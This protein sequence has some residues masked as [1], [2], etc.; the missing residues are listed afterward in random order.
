MR[1]S[2]E[3]ILLAQSLVNR[4]GGLGPGGR[5]DTGG[6]PKHGV[7]VL[8]PVGGNGAH[9][10]TQHVNEAQDHL[11][12]QRRVRADRPI[13]AEERGNRKKNKDNERSHRRT[14]VVPPQPQIKSSKHETMLFKFNFAPV[15]ISDDDHVEPGS[16]DAITVA[17]SAVVGSRGLDQAIHLVREGP[18]HPCLALLTCRIEWTSLFNKKKE[19]CSRMHVEQNNSPD[20]VQF[21]KVTAGRQETTS[22]QNKQKKSST[23]TQSC[24][25]FYQF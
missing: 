18:V 21:N 19:K 15:E 2:E 8:A 24:T 9:N 11:L 20:R 6:V 12:V 1:T 14:P 5:A 23:T 22:T 13:S 25:I 10:D 7:N 4:T 3:D 16:V 17:H